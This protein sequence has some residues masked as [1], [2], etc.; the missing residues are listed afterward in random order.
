MVIDSSVINHVSPRKYLHLALSCHTGNYTEINVVAGIVNTS[1]GA[2]NYR[3]FVRN[4]EVLL[5]Q[6]DL[7]TRVS[8]KMQ[9]S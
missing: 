4:K 9:L 7:V 5:W 1:I 8:K 3:K 6:N 2:S